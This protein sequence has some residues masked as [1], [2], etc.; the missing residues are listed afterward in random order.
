MKKMKKES[1]TVIK[2]CPHIQK[3]CLYVD[4]CRFANAK[5]INIIYCTYAQKNKEGGDVN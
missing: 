3:K 4:C 5:N 1:K 2:E